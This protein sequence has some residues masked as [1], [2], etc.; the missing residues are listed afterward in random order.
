MNEPTLETLSRRIDHLERA[1]WWWKRTAVLLLLATGALALMGQSGQKNR[2]LT[3]EGL[4]LVD[5]AGKT[6]AELAVNDGN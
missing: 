1:S 2:I 3:T 5:K 4:L 6:R